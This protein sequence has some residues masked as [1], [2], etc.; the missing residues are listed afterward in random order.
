MLDRSRNR[1][2][3]EDAFTERTGRYAPGR[4]PVDTSEALKDSEEYQERFEDAKKS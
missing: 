4:K 2:D 3:N 1:Y